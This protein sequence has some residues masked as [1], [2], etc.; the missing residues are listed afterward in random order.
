[1]LHSAACVADPRVSGSGGLKPSLDE[2]VHAG[3]RKGGSGREKE[4]ETERE[5]ERE[6]QRGMEGG[7]KTFW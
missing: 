1:V 4:R 5:R 2:A 7:R 3:G 6:R